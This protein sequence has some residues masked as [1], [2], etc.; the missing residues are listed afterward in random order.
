MDG[1]KGKED[2]VRERTSMIDFGPFLPPGFAFILPLSHLPNTRAVTGKTLK[3][4][5]RWSGERAGQKG[6]DEGGEAGQGLESLVEG[7]GFLPRPWGA[8]VGLWAGP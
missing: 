6:Q 4:K 8:M 7:L 3:E 1:K 2:A 5:E